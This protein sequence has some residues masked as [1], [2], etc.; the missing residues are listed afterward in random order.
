MSQFGRGF[1][2]RDTV[3]LTGWLFA[4]LLLG[5]MVIFLAAVPG[6]S[7]RM[8]VMTV[9]PNSLGLSDCTGGLGHLQCMVKLTETSR[10][11]GAVNWTANSD[12]NTKSNTVTFS[13]AHG[14]LTPGIS[15]TISISAI[16]CQTGSFIFQGSGNATPV[17]V[18]WNCI[19]LPERLEHNYCRLVFNDQDPTRFSRDLQFA[20]SVLEPQINALKFLQGRQV[21]IAIAYGGVD[22]INSPNDRGRG[23]DIATNTYHVLQALANRS[24]LFAQTSYY[25]PLFTSNFPSLNT[26]VDIYLVI[27]QDNPADTCGSDHAPPH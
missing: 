2:V 4:D 26:V 1:Q 10:S 18:F 25:D 7:P 3:L 13:P 22:D 20:K 8:I 27:R 21:G 11:Q 15:A 19:P 23:T 14:I 9:T 12:M 24:P 17:I 5:L 16:P 6:A